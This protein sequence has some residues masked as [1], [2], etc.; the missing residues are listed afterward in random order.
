MKQKQNKKTLI[1]RMEFDLVDWFDDTTVPTFDEIASTLKVISMYKREPE[2]FNKSQTKIINN[3][4]K[5]NSVEKF[6]TAKT[7]AER[8]Q[9][10]FAHD[11]EFATDMMWSKRINVNH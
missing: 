2:G 11:I 9:A 5:E 8:Q 6:I 4:L 3:W 7:Q 10:M 1:V